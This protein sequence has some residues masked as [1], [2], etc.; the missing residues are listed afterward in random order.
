MVRFNVLSLPPLFPVTPLSLSQFNFL[1]FSLFLST[2]QKYWIFYLD[3]QKGKRLFAAQNTMIHALPFSLLILLT[4]IIAMI[5]MMMHQT[6]LPTGD[7]YTCIHVNSVC[8]IHVSCMCRA[9]V[10]HVL[11]MFSACSTCNVQ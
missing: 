3:R 2:N 10:S 4:L 8:H 11:C 9:H 6:L 7:M 1:V 5:M